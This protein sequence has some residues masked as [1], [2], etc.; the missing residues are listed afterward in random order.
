MAGGGDV[1]NPRAVLS[2]DTYVRGANSLEA[3]RPH[4]QS[5]RENTALDGVCVC[6]Y[7]T[8]CLS[9]RF[10]QCA[11]LCLRRLLMSHRCLGPE[12]PAASQ[13]K[14]GDACFI[15][16]ALI[17]HED[18]IILRHVLLGGRYCLK[19]EQRH[20]ASTSPQS[21]GFSERHPT[22]PPSERCASLARGGRYLFCHAHTSAAR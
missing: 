6:V 15:L 19:M 21:Q 7:C 12:G 17:C 5:T 4:A 18:I 13:L 22:P 10:A 9:A 11:C 1:A 2:G 3:N 16:V 20:R 14:E 8:R